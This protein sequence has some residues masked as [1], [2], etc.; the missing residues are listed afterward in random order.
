MKTHGLSHFSKAIMM[1]CNQWDRVRFAKYPDTKKKKKSKQNEKKK[2]TVL[3]ETE[4]SPLILPYGHLRR[5]Q[6]DSDVII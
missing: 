6:A 4:L 5:A 3:T 2:Q 1:L